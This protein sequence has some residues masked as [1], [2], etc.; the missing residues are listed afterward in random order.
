MDAGAALS[1]LAE[2]LAP[3]PDTPG[4]Q[5]VSF[6][7]QRGIEAA[8]LGER[9]G[10]RDVMNCPRLPHFASALAELD[11]LNMV[12]VSG[13]SGSGKSI[14]VWQLAYHY[15]QLGWHVVRHSAASAVMDRQRLSF[16][17]SKR[18]PTVVVVDDTQFHARDFLDYLREQSDARTKILF[19]TTDANWERPNTIRVSAS[20]S[21]ESL[22][23]AF[24]ARRN[25][26]LP[27]VRRF[28]SHIGDDFLSARIERR[29]D[30]AANSRTPWQFAYAL[31][32]GWQQTRHVLDAARDFENDLLL[33]AIAIR[34]IAS[35]DA[36]CTLEQLGFDAGTLGHDAGWAEAAMNRLAAQRVV[37]AGDTI[38]CLHLQ[39]ATA[40]L[41]LSLDSRT[42]DR[43]SKIVA[44]LRGIMLSSDTPLRGIS[45]LL[46]EIRSYRPQILAD[47]LRTRLLKRCF[48]VHTH[49]ER[50]DACFVLANLLGWKDTTAF[51]LV[52]GFSGQM[53]AWVA[54]ANAEDAYGVA[55]LLNNLFNDDK[56]LCRRFLDDIDP[57]P[58]AERLAGID[59]KDGYAWGDLL[60]RL[61]CGC[62]Q[63]WAARFSAHIPRERIR[64]YVGRF[65][66]EDLGRLSKFIDGIA[67]FD[68]DFALECLEKT[69]P[70]Y[71][72][73]FGRD[74]LGTY[75]ELGDLEYWVLGHP[76]FQRPNP[77]K[78]QRSIAKSM[79]D[80]IDSPTI[81]RQVL[82]CPFGDW[83]YY[84]RLL[85][86]VR[87]IHVAKIGQIVSAMDWRGLDDA[88]GDKWNVPPREL[89]LLLGT[90][91]TTS[92]CE[93]INSWIEQHAGRIEK[94]DP[95]LAG[96]SPRAVVT[97]VGS[98]HHVD[99]G[100]HNGS[101]WDL[102]AW[103][104]ARIAS[105][106]KGTVKTVLRQN[107]SH[108]I[109]Q[110]TELSLP[111]GLPRFLGLIQEL[112]STF[113]TD[114]V[115]TLSPD[116]VRE[117]WT[118]S[119][120]DHRKEERYAARQ[121]LRRIAGEGIGSVCDLASELLTTVRYRGPT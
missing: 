62:S 86:W 5:S 107:R 52:G 44:L 70:L 110:L 75:R 21:V 20:A 117:K 61:R 108:L 71:N 4:W 25:E 39:S 115:A 74:S 90:L 111:A 6:D 109:K 79:F 116:R 24:K 9:L 93:P 88:I 113:L 72:A 11:A 66:G 98:G 100:G 40:I 22:A 47:E 43:S 121:V 18:W 16:I 26:I 102:Q 36:G 2:E 91:T 81:V 89:R 101:D 31:R 80:G 94:M 68:L 69:L 76:L 92:D 34:Q 99:L 120:S 45:W 35:L 112:D 14:T 73:G 119:L 95:I 67:G 51:E 46:S 83:E 17:A 65:H 96:L 3:A 105:V 32:G 58:I 59:C 85:G 27:I 57:C 54:E 19:G 33:T 82:S 48:N 49:A 77:S 63:E 50:R 41:N 12:E 1:I 56:Q 10:P 114:V 15:N 28:D 103:A 106:D 64:E 53:R 13:T 84:A 118:K 29:I 55:S 87:G 8:V 104:L 30:L 37:L 7:N 78:R 97:I 23:K 38:R 42:P 60:G